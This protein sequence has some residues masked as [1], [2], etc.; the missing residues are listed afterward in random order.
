[1]CMYDSSTMFHLIDNTSVNEGS[2]ERG[3]FGCLG[4]NWCNLSRKN[5]KNLHGVFHIFCTMAHKYLN[6]QKK[7][8]G[9]FFVSHACAQKQ[10][11]A[12]Q[13]FA[14]WLPCCAKKLF[15]IQGI[16]DPGSFHSISWVPLWQYYSFCDGIQ[17]HTGCMLHF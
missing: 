2:S 10:K 5:I 1:M 3:S 7:S 6:M 15:S 12:W 14:F 9:W 17:D 13:C 4:R 11:I 16:P 8:L